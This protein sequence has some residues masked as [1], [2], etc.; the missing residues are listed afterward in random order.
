MALSEA[1][2]P[3]SIAHQVIRAQKSLLHN[4]VLVLKED[5]Y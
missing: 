2:I 3:V 4:T 5:K 1:Y